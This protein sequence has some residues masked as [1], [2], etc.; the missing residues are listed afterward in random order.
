MTQNYSSLSLDSDRA[1]GTGGPSS[2]YF[3]PSPSPRASGGVPRQHAKRPF[4]ESMLGQGT[5]LVL[6]VAQQRLVACP[7]Q[8]DVVRKSSLD[9]GCSGEMP[10]R[11]GCVQAADKAAR[12]TGGRL[13]EAK[14]E[15]PNRTVFTLS[16]KKPEARTGQ[17]LGVETLATKPPDLSLTPGTCKAG[18]NKRRPQSSSTS[19]CLLCRVDPHT[20]R[21]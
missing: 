14:Y 10:S 15:S 4:L 16:P 20:Y 11:H 7:H 6:E 5:W 1:P 13:R 17:G 8:Q 3:H 21:K 18:D 2:A 12:L 19:T 9:S